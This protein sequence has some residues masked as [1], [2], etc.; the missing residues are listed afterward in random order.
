MMDGK[1]D[2]VDTMQKQIEARV[3]EL[4]EKVEPRP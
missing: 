1:I 4:E 2:A 3:V